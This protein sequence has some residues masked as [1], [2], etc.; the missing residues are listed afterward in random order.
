[1]GSEIANPQAKTILTIDEQEKS[2]VLDFF[3]YLFFPLW[4]FLG[5]FR[6]RVMRRLHRISQGCRF[7]LKLRQSSVKAAN[8]F[9]TFTLPV[10]GACSPSP[11]G[12]GKSHSIL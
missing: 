4:Y 3:L 2:A 7:W 1:M 11:H 12:N 10:L 9:H 8:A 5:Q 6:H